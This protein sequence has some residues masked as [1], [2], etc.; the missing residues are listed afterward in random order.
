MQKLFDSGGFGIQNVVQLL[1]LA[2]CLQTSIGR[3]MTRE[4]LT[5]AR[6]MTLLDDDISD[7]LFDQS[8]ESVKAGKNFFN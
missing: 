7:E 5:E 6:E 3:R 4:L 8:L 1:Y 2:Y